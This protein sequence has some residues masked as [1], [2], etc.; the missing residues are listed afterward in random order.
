MEQHFVDFSTTVVTVIVVTEF[1]KNL[2]GT[3]NFR[4]Q[5]LSWG[6]GIVLC[7]A[8][9]LLGIGYLA[10]VAHWYV[11]ALWGLGASLAANGVFD[12]PIV[13]SLIKVIVKQF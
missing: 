8:V 9:W 12:V 13:R 7:I 6:T 5:L 4:S 10:D 11:A 1:L 2:I 3:T